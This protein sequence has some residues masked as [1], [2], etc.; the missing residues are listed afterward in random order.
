MDTQARIVMFVVLCFI[1]M[2]LLRDMTSYR[3][4]LTFYL[5]NNWDFSK[6]SGQQVL[7]IS[8]GIAVPM[9]NKTRVYFGFPVQI[10]I[11]AVV[12]GFLLAKLLGP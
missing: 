2:L 10:I 11:Q 6:D 3:K 7:L 1:A 4:D 12:V 5:H 9:S 8:P